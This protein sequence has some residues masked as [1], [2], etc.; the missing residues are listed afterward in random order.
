MAGFQAPIEKHCV[1]VVESVATGLFPTTSSVPTSRSPMPPHSA[2]AADD[3]SDS[4]EDPSLS[5]LVKLTKYKVKQTKTST[6][7]T[8]N[9]ETK[10]TVTKTFR[11]EFEKSEDNYYDFL[12]AILE[13]HNITGLSVGKKSVFRLKMQVPPAK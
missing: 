8:L 10:E 2:P 12:K 3:H 5:V 4:D 11:F 6:G 7:K 9:K 1:R 13:V